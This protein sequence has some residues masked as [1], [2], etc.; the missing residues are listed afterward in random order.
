[1]MR[2][3]LVLA[4]PPTL[5]HGPS[6]WLFTA[7]AAVDGNVI[8]L[9]SQGEDGTLARDLYGRWERDQD[10]TATWGKGRTGNLAHLGGQ[11]QIDV[12]PLIGFPKSG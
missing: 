2:P 6:R 7:M 8:L 10:E 1:M 9:T 11:L 4:T 5:S 3:K 12:S